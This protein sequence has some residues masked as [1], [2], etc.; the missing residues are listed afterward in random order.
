VCVCVSSK[1]IPMWCVCLLFQKGFPQITFRPKNEIKNKITLEKNKKTKP[2][3]IK[4]EY[5]GEGGVNK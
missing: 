2:G 4:E 1:K 5:F 3:L